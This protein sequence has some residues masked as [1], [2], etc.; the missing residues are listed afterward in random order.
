ML[1]LRDIYS[2][3]KDDDDKDDDW[4]PDDHQTAGC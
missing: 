1:A 4:W 3:N 2:Y